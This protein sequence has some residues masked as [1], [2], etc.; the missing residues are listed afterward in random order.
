MQERDK[1][2]ARLRV[3]ETAQQWCPLCLNGQFLAYLNNN[4]HSGFYPKSNG[5]LLKEIG[6]SKESFQ[7]PA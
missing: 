5:F 4:A 3:A 1:R 2:R 7:Q 6:F